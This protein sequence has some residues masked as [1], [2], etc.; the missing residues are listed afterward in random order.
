MVSRYSLILLDSRASIFYLD[1]DPL[2][3]ADHLR[4]DS[5]RVCSR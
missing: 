3:S 2:T 5:G 1:A 4:S